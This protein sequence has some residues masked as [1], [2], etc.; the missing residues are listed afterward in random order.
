MALQGTFV[1]LCSLAVLSFSVAQD[2]TCCSRPKLVEDLSAFLELEGECNGA[3]SAEQT[4]TILKS[5]RNLTDVL[6]KQQLKGCQHAEPKNC[7]EAKV[8]E[9]GGLACVTVANKRYCKPM[10]NHGYDFDFIRRSRVFDECSEQT[11]YKWQ[12][13]YIGGNRLAVCN[14]ARIQVSGAKTAYF[15]EDQSCITTKSN[16][17]LHRSFVENLK[18]ELKNLGIEGEPQNP[19][20]VCG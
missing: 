11:G 12:T 17:T 18:T 19:C 14:E 5:L 20:L 1:W 10:C 2:D 8:P 15:P 3:W 7:T 13:Q 16:C 6:Q 9:N 4:A